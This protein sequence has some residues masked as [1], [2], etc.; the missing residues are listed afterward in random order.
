MHRQE[1]EVQEKV[2]TS[3][4]ED[5]W[6]IL[7]RLRGSQMPC[8]D[9]CGMGTPFP[10][11]ALGILHHLCCC[12]SHQASVYNQPPDD[13][14]PGGRMQNERLSWSLIYLSSTDMAFPYGSVPNSKTKFRK[15]QMQT[16]CF[17]ENGPITTS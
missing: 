11:G 17:D 13:Q 10:Q 12:H 4:A 2:V 9:G 1:K 14:K 6:E 5:R 15:F 8:L 3:A 7:A 16:G